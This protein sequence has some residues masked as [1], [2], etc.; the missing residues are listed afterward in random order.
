MLVTSSHIPSIY[1]RVHLVT[2]HPGQLAMSWHRTHS[3][4][5]GYTQRDATQSR[6]V[7]HTCAY[8]S[9]HQT[10]TDHRRIHRE[11]TD[12]LFLTLTPT[13]TNRA[14]MHGSAIC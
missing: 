4:N 11:I 8:G 6:P 7:C 9:M 14:P 5:A 13:P 10:K 12:N 3:I 1:D 2:G